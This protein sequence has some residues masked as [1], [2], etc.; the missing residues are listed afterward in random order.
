MVGQLGHNLVIAFALACVLA[1]LEVRTRKDAL[2]VGLLVWVGFQAAAVAVSVLHENY[3]LGLYL[4]H[5]GDAL[6]AT[7]LMALIL[8]AWRR[9][10]RRDVEISPSVSTSS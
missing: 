1:R 7:L 10:V 4:I 6:Q 5:V 3:P 8:T 9:D 2:R